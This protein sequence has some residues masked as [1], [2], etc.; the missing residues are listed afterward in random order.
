MQT[1][2]G[3]K[4]TQWRARDTELGYGEQ[5]CSPYK[6]KKGGGEKIIKMRKDTIEEFIQSEIYANQTA[7]VQKALQ[8]KLFSVAE[9]YNLYREFDGLLLYPNTCT[10][11]RFVSSCLDSETGECETCFEKNKK[12]QGIDEWFLVSVFLGKQLL[13]AGAPVIDNTY[14]MWWGR[15]TGNDLSQ[16]DILT[17]IYNEK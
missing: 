6:F 4:T 2:R 16:D 14:G 7:L 12:P 13:I 10:H 17:K 8:L 9:I 11:C 1:L 5:E 3:E 15:T